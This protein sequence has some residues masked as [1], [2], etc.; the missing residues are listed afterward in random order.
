MSSTVDEATQ[1]ADL[2]PHSLEAEQAILGGLM[3]TNERYDSVAELL[4]AEDFYSDSHRQIFSMIGHLAVADE[5]FDIVTLSEKLSQHGELERIGGLNYLSEIT[6]NTPSAA[7]IT[8]YSR[9]VREHAT[10]RQLIAAA[11]EIARTGRNPAGLDANDL[12][13]LAEKRL[14]AIIDERPKE[15]GLEVVDGLLKRTLERIDQLFHAENDITGITTGL[16]DLN[17]YTSGWQRGELIVLAARPSMGKTALALNFIEAALLSQPKPVLM[18]SMEMPSESLI[19]RMLSSLGHVEQNKIR[20]GNLTEEDWPKLT[21]AVQKLKGASL[22]I[23]DT[24]ALTPQDIRARLRRITREKDTPGLVV[25]DYLQLMHTADTS[26]GRTQEIS[27]IS[28]SLKAMAKEFDC[29]LIALSQL[30]RGVEQRPDKRPRNADLRESG[31]IE[32]DADVVLFIY[33]DEYYNEDSPDKGVAELILGKQRNGETGTC[34]AAFIGQYTRFE[35][36]AP[37]YMRPD[38]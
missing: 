18:F 15:G 21:S 17:K 22:Y 13:Q 11:Q 34:R 38:H 6:K 29:P 32:Q 3:L 4:K 20:N 24:P 35:N 25:V 26:E 33:R 2:L 8:A 23:D 28:R 30:N 31:A 5:P 1:P 19:M 14:T 16:Q 7:N 37:D 9:V 27:E 10:V 36:L 12:L